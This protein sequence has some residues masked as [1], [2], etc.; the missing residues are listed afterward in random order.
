MSSLPAAPIVIDEKFV[1]TP[2]SVS[3]FDIKDMRLMLPAGSFISNMS[4]KITSSADIV[5]VVFSVVMSNGDIYSPVPISKLGMEY[6]AMAYKHTMPIGASF[7]TVTSAYDETEV[8]LTLPTSIH[9]S[10]IVVI[11][12]VTYSYDDVINV[13]LKEHETLQIQVSNTKLFRSLK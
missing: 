8:K 12:D 10:E 6:F 2:Y 7:I 1:V 9:T 13:K 11:G 4:L 5:V 3:S